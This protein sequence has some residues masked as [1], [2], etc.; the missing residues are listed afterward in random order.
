M[1]KAWQTL[2]V[3]SIAWAASVA[4]AATTMETAL[5]YPEMVDDAVVENSNS[6]ASIIIDEQVSETSYA[7]NCAD[8]CNDG[9]GDL[10]QSLCAPT[11]K[12][13]AGAV[14]ASARLRA[15]PT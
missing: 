5:H 13:R 2:S 3:S 7:A 10:C 9:C 12:V 8:D 6:T 4:S 11:W 14:F 1:K 15:Q